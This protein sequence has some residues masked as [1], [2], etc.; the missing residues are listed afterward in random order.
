MS[1][2]FCP[3]CGYQLHRS[4]SR[5]VYEKFIKLVSRQR[6]YRCHECSW[7]GWLGVGKKKVPP[8]PA[9]HKFL[10]FLLALFTI[11]LIFLMAIYFANS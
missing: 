5:S 9:K 1:K 10:P 11:L 7:R 8:P 6:L 2:T 3:D 4:H